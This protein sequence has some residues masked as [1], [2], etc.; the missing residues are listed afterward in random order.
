MRIWQIKQ[1]LARIVIM[2]SFSMR[3]NKLSI[4]KR[5]LKMSHR[6]A[7]TAEQQRS[8]SKEA[9]VVTAAVEIEAAVTKALVVAAETDGKSKES[10]CSP[11]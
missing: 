11:F 3:V 7:L 8:S 9:V 2:N 6:D 1:Y 5:D 4:K 10:K